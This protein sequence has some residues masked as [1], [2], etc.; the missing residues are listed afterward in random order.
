MGQYLLKEDRWQEKFDKSRSF[1]EKAA[2]AVARQGGSWRFVI[3]L[4]GFLAVW[5]GLNSIL[6]NFG[7][8]WDAFPFI[9]LNL[10]LSTL[11]AFQA[12]IIMMSQ[13]RQSQIDHIIS[14]YVSTIILRSEQQIRQVSAK[15]DLLVNNQW[16]RLLEIQEIELDLLRSSHLPQPHHAEGNLRNRQLSFGG[17]AGTLTRRD[18]LP[19]LVDF[20]SAEVEPDGHLLFLLKRFF[21]ML[22]ADDTLVFSHWLHDG[23]NFTGAI[24]DIQFDLRR[25][26]LRTVSYTLSLSDPNANL[27][28]LLSGDNVVW[29]RN[30]FDV[31]CMK[32][33]GQI[34]K[35]GIKWSDGE[36]VTFANGELPPRYKPAFAL[37]RADKITDTWK[38]TLSSLV[39]TYQPPPAFALLTLGVG[40]VLHTVTCEFYPPEHLKAGR[41]PKSRLFCRKLTEPD[42][43]THL[44]L[45]K[46]AANPKS[47]PQYFVDGTEM[48]AQYDWPSGAVTGT[49]K[50]PT[51]A[52]GETGILAG[53]KGTVSVER[54]FEGPNVWCFWCLDGKVSLHGP[55]EV[56]MSSALHVN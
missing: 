11:A 30:D 22:D 27:D 43:E 49:V 7:Y 37:T 5:M 55:L 24:S 14:D 40:E 18:T 38:R 54:V 33:E 21:D 12:P 26:K 9:L 48:L 46:L 41:I 8:A 10:I 52:P 42:T 45:R 36:L 34:R 32:M 3:G 17:I 28:D 31:P 19:G 44:L 6:N 29:I 2:D 20:W 13:N 47:D 56:N 23:D 51:N 25:G 39:I 1:G 53:L 15:M 50:P 16:R 4:I 35:L